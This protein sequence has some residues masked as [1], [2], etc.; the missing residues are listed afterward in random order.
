MIDEVVK[1][2][3][4]ACFCRDGEHS[5]PKPSALDFAPPW[6]GWA[7]DRMWAQYGDGHAGVCLAFDRRKLVDAFTAAFQSRGELIAEEV[8]YSDDPRSLSYDNGRIGKVGGECYATEYRRQHAPTLYL[9]KRLDYGGEREFRLVLLDDDVTGRDAFVPIR[10]AL[11][12]VMFGDRFPR[13][14]LPCVDAVMRRE[15]L[16]AYQFVYESGRNVVA[17]RYFGSG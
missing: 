8:A 6:A 16:A 12:Y 14:Y 13:A 5:S 11:A 2:A 10:G 15:S 3:Q 4:I 1:R 17:R 7:R 9:L